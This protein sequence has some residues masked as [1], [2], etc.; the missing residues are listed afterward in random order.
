[1]NRLLLLLLLVT[2][3]Q[4]YGVASYA[5]GN[6]LLGD[7]DENARTFNRGICAGYL[8]GISD[9]IEHYKEVFPSAVPAGWSFSF[10]DICKPNGV[11]AGQLRKVWVKWAN[12]NP[13]RLHQTGKSLVLAAFYAAWPCR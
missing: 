6:L 4:A 9:S 3:G 7:C 8:M 12:E 5:D 13:Q 1:M 11:T 2:S 10:N